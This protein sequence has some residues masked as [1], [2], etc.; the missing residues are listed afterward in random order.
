MNNLFYTLDNFPDGLFYYAP[1][2][3]NDNYENSHDISKIE[4][5]LSSVES[6]CDLLISLD[7]NN[8]GE[9]F[10]SIIHHGMENHC[11]VVPGGYLVLFRSN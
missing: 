7:K 11:V 1:L 8:F 3:E 9:N 10:H 6:I 5:N 4:W 2:Y